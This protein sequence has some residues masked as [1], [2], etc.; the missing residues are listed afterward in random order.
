MGFVFGE[1]QSREQSPWAYDATN[2]LLKL[3]PLYM[4]AAGLSGGIRYTNNSLA[5]FTQPTGGG[6]DIVVPTGKTLLI[7]DLFAHN[8]TGTV[9]C[10][11]LDNGAAIGAGLITPAAGSNS[12][13]FVTPLK[14][15]A[16]HT[17][18][19]QVNPLGGTATFFAVQAN[20]VIL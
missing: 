14:V 13:Q 5:S 10:E 4:A 6:S 16:A 12:I 2:D 7:T 9:N 8:V 11:L 15:I 18:S 3:G 19:F 20:Y 17:L 1:V